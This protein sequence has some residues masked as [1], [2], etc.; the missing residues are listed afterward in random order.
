MFDAWAMWDPGLAIAEVDH[1]TRRIASG[2]AAP[3][4]RE[5][6]SSTAKLYLTKLLPLVPS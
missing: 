2:E 3:H 6:T 1:P 5:C 4:L